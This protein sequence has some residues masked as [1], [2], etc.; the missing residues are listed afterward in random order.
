MDR[1]RD[2]EQMA[3]ESS[4]DPQAG[5]DTTLQ[6]ETGKAP[7][8]LSWSALRFFR[9]PRRSLIPLFFLQTEGGVS[10]V[11]GQTQPPEDRA[12]EPVLK[13]QRTDG[14]GILSDYIF[15]LSLKVSRKLGAVTIEL[16]EPRQKSR[17]EASQRSAPPCGH[18]WKNQISP[19]THG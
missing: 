7:E 2:S 14:C 8:R 16:M 10:G 4:D 15:A 12:E 9:R 13:K 1:K 17:H 3:T 11:G 5:T 19:P 18:C 6:S